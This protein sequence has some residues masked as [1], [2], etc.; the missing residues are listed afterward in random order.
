[1]KRKHGY[2]RTYLLG[3]KSIITGV[4]V[5]LISYGVLVY[6]QIHTKPDQPIAACAASVPVYYHRA[7][8][9]MPFPATVDPGKFKR[10]DI[11]K[12]YRVAK[13]IPGVLAQQPC[14]CYC[15]RQGHHGL[16]DCFRTEHAA[17]CDICVKEALLAGEMHRQGKSAEDI[18]AAIIR[19]DWNHVNTT[20]RE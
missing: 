19:G 17:S 3:H 11:Q 16:L 20:S 6:K 12:A 14:Y 8:D 9:A 5:L 7:E 4:S 1:M 2:K 18:R 15:Q 13:D 10:P